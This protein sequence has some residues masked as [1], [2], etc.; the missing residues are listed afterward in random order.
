VGNANIKHTQ[1]R[2]QQYP[3]AKAHRALQPPQH[4]TNREASSYEWG[5]P[6]AQVGSFRL[7]DEVKGAKNDISKSAT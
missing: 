4:L 1:N 7:A 2:R 3:L 5:G 6:D